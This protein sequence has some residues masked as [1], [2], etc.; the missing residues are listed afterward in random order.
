MNPFLTATRLDLIG[1]LN[2]ELLLGEMAWLH[3]RRESLSI[4]DDTMLHRQVSIDFT[5]P[6]DFGERDWPSVGR[7]HSDD[8]P[9]FAAPLLLLQKLPA[10]LMNF[11]LRD[12]SGRSLPLMSREDNAAISAQTLAHM[13]R[14]LA[15]ILTGS[16]LPPTLDREMNR[17]ARA[18]AGAAAVHLRRF[19]EPLPEDG[20]PNLRQALLDD[21][22]LGWWIRA[23]AH[24]SIVMAFFPPTEDRRRVIKLSYN[25]PVAPVSR[26]RM[27]A[28]QFGVAPWDLW[29]ENAFIGSANYHLEAQA[30]P[31]L[32]VHHGALLDVESG[33]VLDRE[34]MFV[35]RV[36]LYAPDAHER[37][38][39]L[40]WIS[41]RANYQGLLGT[42]VSVAAFVVTGVVV[43]WQSPHRI[44]GNPTAAPSLLLLLPG[45]V[46]SVVGRPDPHALTT[47]VLA[48]VRRLLLAAGFGAF[49]AAAIVALS[50]KV[51]KTTSREEVADYLDQ[52]L[53]W[54][55]YAVILCAAPILLAVVFNLPLT[56][57]LW[58]LL[59]RVVNVRSLARVWDVLRVPWY[60][61]SA[62]VRM[63]P[64]AAVRHAVDDAP[65]LLRPRETDQ[66]DRGKHSVRLVRRRQL[67]GLDLWTLHFFVRTADAPDGA[68]IVCAVGYEAPWFTRWVVPL[69]L[70]WQVRGLRRRLLELMA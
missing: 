2:A 3:R 60:E 22:Q 66:V 56:H 10:D 15:P 7:G 68:E 34:G 17:I 35:R 45:L 55:A 27:L 16:D 14:Q 36:H 54:P 33:E 18:S 20:Y 4:L 39:A 61:L 51:G 62:P 13:A 59:R 43:V 47:R 12:E 37:R 5:L 32:R 69:A 46:A 11:D 70:Q 31:G 8:A 44:A 41:L 9:I 64:T 48:G 19:A 63:S 65:M 29:V 24:S 58:R 57:R 49:A 38:T 28:V 52:W 50:P 40:S 23:L 26:L 6:D 30:P 53:R 21:D 67:R 25:E 1:F 42:S